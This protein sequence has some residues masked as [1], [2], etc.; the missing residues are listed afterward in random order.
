M[1]DDCL[2]SYFLLFPYF[3]Y[4]T[5]L[6]WFLWAVLPDPLVPPLD[7]FL[8]YL[9]MLSSLNILI[10]IV[11]LWFRR[12]IASRTETGYWSQTLI[13]AEP[14]ELRDPDSLVFLGGLLPIPNPSICYSLRIL[15]CGGKWRRSVF[16]SEI[17]T[18]FREWSDL[19]FRKSNGLWGPFQ[20]PCVF[21]RIQS[22]Y[23][24]T[25]V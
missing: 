19:P 4:H 16:F 5:F 21:S 24:T 20:G 2:G 12:G 22:T 17:Q 3:I 6:Q 9:A 10:F 18:L 14:W 23:S 15:A 8:V 25:L 11:F 1:D 13:I 7:S